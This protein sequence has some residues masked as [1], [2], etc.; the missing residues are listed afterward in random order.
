MMRLAFYAPMKPPD[1]PRPSGDRTIARNLIDAL[2]STGAA[3]TLTSRFRSRDGDG[4]ATSQARL[5]QA[6]EDEIAATIPQGRAG[7]WQAWITYHNYYKAPDLVGPA[8]S[9]S[10]G[11]PYILIEAT[12]AKKRLVGPWADFA[13]RAEAACDAADAIFF[14]SQ[15]DGQTLQRDA[16]EGQKLIHL[17]PF[18]PMDELP[19][20]AQGDGG[21][22]SVGM[23]RAGDKLASYRVLAETLRHLQTPD[24]QITVAGDGP[25][26]DEVHR[27]MSPFGK[28][29]RF[30]GALC[31]AALAAQYHQARVFIWPGVNEALGMVY[32][33][34]QAH[35]VP[36][37]AQNR[38][39][40]RELFAPDAAL[41]EVEAGPKALAAALD[42]LL[43][44]PEARHTLGCHAREHVARHHLRPVA[45]RTLMTTL[46]GLCA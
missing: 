38:P 6:A 22:L 25:A 10:L 16:P 1:D 20:Q 30:T 12:R 4:D 11:I 41:P 40:L 8:V 3:V 26:R 2:K 44:T 34:A 33:E 13:Q 18:L 24:W 28:A 7:G 17:R 45:A 31:E 36:V 19:A 29:V 35:G 14:L 46:E 15:R 21:I 9:K 27:M 42:H 39:G 32:L 5:M 37:L 23:M 43:S